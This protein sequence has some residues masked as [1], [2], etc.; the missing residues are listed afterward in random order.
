LPYV[1]V[2]VRVAALVEL[3]LLEAQGDVMAMR[4]SEVRLRKQRADV[5]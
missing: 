3:G 1:I 2:Q 4:H 5:A